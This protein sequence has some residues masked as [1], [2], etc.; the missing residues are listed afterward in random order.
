MQ[1]KI[2]CYRIAV[3]LLL[4]SLIMTQV[5]TTD[6]KAYAATDPITGKISDALADVKEAEDELKDAQATYKKILKENDSS[7]TDDDLAYIGWEF[8]DHMVETAY[9]KDKK[10]VAKSDLVALDRLT[11]QGNLDK[12]Y[13]HKPS[14][15]A[16]LKYNNAAKTEAKTFEGRVKESLSIKNIEKAL[17]LIDRCNYLRK[18]NGRKALK[19]SPYMM[20]GAAVSGLITFKTGSHTYA[21]SGKFVHINGRKITENY[22]W[23]YSDPFYGWYTVEKRRAA[24]GEGGTSHLRVLLSGNCYQ[25]GAAWNGSF[26]L[27]NQIFLKTTLG[28]SYTVSEFRQLF[29]DYVKEAKAQIKADKKAILKGTKK[30]EFL[31]NAENSL[32]KAQKKLAKVIKSYTPRVKAKA[33]DYQSVNLSFSTPKGFTGIQVYRAFRSSENTFAKIKAF[34]PSVTSYQ[35][36]G[37]LPSWSCYYKVRLYKKYGGKI[38]YTPFSEPKKAT[39]KFEKIVNVD[40]EFYEDVDVLKLEWTEIDG[41]DGYE[42][43]VKEYTE[44]DEA[45]EMMTKF[46]WVKGF[47]IE[48]NFEIPLNMAYIDAT[49]EGPYVIKIRPYRKN[50]EVYLYGKF[51]DPI[52]VIIQ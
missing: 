15:A 21:K 27:A 16:I 33:A 24:A 37:L 51:S 47:R 22:A 39:P 46:E 17:D 3:I 9:A 26:N 19:V 30:P 32:E 18:I 5:F 7:V 41:A 1:A 11:V 29:R 45:F 34:K 6:L 50:A 52:D 49:I 14:R 13:E 28:T 23:G 40:S 36:T 12:A 4:V 38:Y 43:W 2:F 20:A 35:D 8:L 48:S 25:T 44:E 10:K 31:I 42:I